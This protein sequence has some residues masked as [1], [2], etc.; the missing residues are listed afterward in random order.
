MPG[1]NSQRRGTAHTL[2]NCCVVLCSVCFVSFCVLFVCK[3]V[4]Y[5][6][7]RVTTQLQLINISII[8]IT[9]R[10]REHQNLLSLQLV[11]FLVGLRT[12][13]NPCITPQPDLLPDVFCLM[14]RIFRLM[15]VLL[16]LYINI[17]I[18]IYTRINIKQK[19]VFI[20]KNHTDYCCFNPLNTKRRPLY[21]KT[22][23]VPRCKHFSSR[24]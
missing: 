20:E 1:Y 2:P 13:Q 3:C 9:N 22:Q 4:L 21:L 6:C 17:Y 10:I 7:H 8:M 19:F 15:L 24:L 16:Y 14:V 5:Y 12:Y 23:S 11:S 18:Y